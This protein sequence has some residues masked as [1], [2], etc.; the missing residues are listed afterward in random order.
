[1]L[2]FTRIFWSII[3][4][5]IQSLAFKY[6]LQNLSF[7]SKWSLTNKKN[8][9]VSHSIEIRSSKLEKWDFIRPKRNK[10]KNYG[11][12]TQFSYLHKQLWHL[13]LK[14]QQNRLIFDFQ[15]CVDDMRTVL[16]IFWIKWYLHQIKNWSILTNEWTYKQ[17]MNSNRMKTIVK[18]ISTQINLNQC[19]RQTIKQI[20]KLNQQQRIWEQPMS[21]ERDNF[22]AHCKILDR[23]K[24]TFVVYFPFR[25][26]YLLSR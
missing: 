24:I 3:I 22:H 26:D 5:S 23:I 6:L 8:T 12:F 14:W 13:L 11:R 15:H 19:H 1:M 16:C 2:I 25:Y 4:F 7:F 9:S 20:N 21:S 10:M 18:K 17:T